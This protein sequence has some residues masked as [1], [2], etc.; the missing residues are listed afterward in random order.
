[1]VDALCLIKA[2]KRSVNIVAQKVADLD[3]VSEVYTVSGRYDIAV[4]M[5]AKSNKE[6][7]DIITKHMLRID[8]IVDTE[9]M[10][11]FQDFTRHKVKSVFSIGLES[12]EKLL[13]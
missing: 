7:A 3:H 1:M 13:A 10:L 2:K 11:A 6:I 4:I 12:D 9:T 5:H 8:G